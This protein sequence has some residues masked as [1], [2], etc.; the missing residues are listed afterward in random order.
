MGSLTPLFVFLPPPS[1]KFFLS[2]YYVLRIVLRALGQKGLLPQ[3]ALL[4]PEVTD[5]SPITLIQGQ[6]SGGGC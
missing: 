3:G 2:T 5:S 1:C 4:P 6:S